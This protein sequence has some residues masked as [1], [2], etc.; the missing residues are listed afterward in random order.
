MRDPNPSLRPGFQRL[1]RAGIPVEVGLI[2]DEATALNAPFITF[3][4]KIGLTSS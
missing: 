3:H 4:K 1:R 2:R